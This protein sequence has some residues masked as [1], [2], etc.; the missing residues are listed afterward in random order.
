MRLFLISLL[1]LFFLSG[2]EEKDPPEEFIGKW[3]QVGDSSTGLVF[4]K[5][6]EGIRYSKGY[7]EP[8]KWEEGKGVV[9]IR[10]SWGSAWEAKVKGDML[11]FS[12]SGTVLEKAND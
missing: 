8:F 12:A 3:S 11:V 7:Q 2:C 9:K 5:D 6:G 4:M 10:Y 1:S